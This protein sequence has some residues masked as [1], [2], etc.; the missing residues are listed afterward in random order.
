MI[1]NN[2]K[3]TYK[4]AL[5]YIELYANPIQIAMGDLEK[6]YIKDVNIVSLISQ[7]MVD[8]SSHKFDKEVSF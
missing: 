3:D 2:S 4:K 7:I 5:E 6:G 8:E 1:W